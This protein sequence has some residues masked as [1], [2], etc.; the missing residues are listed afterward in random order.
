MTHT[1][2][3]P[4][5]SLPSLF[6]HKWAVPTLAAF[7]AT[8]GGAK[9]VTLRNQ[10]GASRDSLRRTLAALIDAGLITRNPGYGHPM[11]PEYILTS[12]GRQLAPASA[13][14]LKKLKSLGIEEI[15][16]KKWSLPV[17]CALE[18]AG[19]RFGRVC[20]AL[21][22]VTPRALTQALRDLQQAGIVKRR[23][24]DGY[25]PYTEYRLT[26]SGRQLT[27]MVLPLAG[28]SN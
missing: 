17:A 19:V 25:P 14:L 24:V 10:V 21:G 5:G 13:T 28:L 16:L 15:A 12:S 18:A 27:A 9:F 22:E 6:H 7:D 2:E 11:R 23:L 1:A 4:L 20:A 3:H 8:G 26:R